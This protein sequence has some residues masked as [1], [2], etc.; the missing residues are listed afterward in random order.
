MGHSRR[1]EHSADLPKPQGG[2]EAHS[3]HRRCESCTA[4]GPA[5]TIPQVRQLQTGPG[6]QQWEEGRPQRSPSVTDSLQYWKWSKHNSTTTEPTK[7]SPHKTTKKPQEHANLPYPEQGIS[8]PKDS[9]GAEP[10]L[11]PSSAIPFGSTCC[12]L[13]VNSA[14]L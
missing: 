7:T 8:V 2:G 10:S 5:R 11:A 9:S 3:S 6:W 13:A 1:R 14:V 4:P 12:T